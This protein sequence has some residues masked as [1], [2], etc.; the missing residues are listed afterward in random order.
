MIS[1]YLANKIIDECHAHKTAFVQP[2]T[3]YLAAS[4]TTP[5]A[6]GGSITEPTNGAYARVAMTGSTFSAAA[7]GTGSNS[8]TISFPAATAAWNVS[9][10]T[11][12]AVMDAS[13]AGNMLWSV[14]LATSKTVASGDILQVLAANLTFNLA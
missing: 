12:Y 7:S 1:T 5:T 3:I 2:S 14:A 11:Y 10:I 13:T 4:S 9:P 8:G 6:A